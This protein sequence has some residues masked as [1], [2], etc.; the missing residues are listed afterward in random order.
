MKHRIHSMGIVI[1][2]YNDFC[3]LLLLVILLAVC[4]FS[5]S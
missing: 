5:L 1:N 4:C 3:A 2:Q